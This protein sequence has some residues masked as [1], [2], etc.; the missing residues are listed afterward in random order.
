M[1]PQWQCDPVTSSGTGIP[2]RRLLR[3]A[4]LWSLHEI[5]S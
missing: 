5:K 3:L 4:G 1:S 2:F